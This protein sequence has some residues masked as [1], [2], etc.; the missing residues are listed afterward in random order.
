MLLCYFVSRKDFSILN[1]TKINSYSIAHNLDCGGKSKIVIAENPNASDEDFVLIKEGKEIKFGG[2]IDKIDNANGEMKH[3]ISCLEIEQL[4]N[5]EIFLSD[6]DIIKTTGIED[7]IAATI[8]NYFA[9]T[10]DSFIDLSY[11][12]CNAATHTKINAKPPAEDGI[13]NFKTYLGNVKQQYGIFL[14]FD[15]TSTHL[16]I[17][18][19]KKEQSAMQIDTTLTDIYNCEES[20]KIK[21]LS[22]LSVLWRNTT[23]Q[24]ETMRYFYLHSD[25]SV[26]EVDKDRI[27]GT[28]SAICIE[29]ETEEEMIQAAKD[30][31]KSN[32]YSHSIEADILIN[33]K[34][35]PI[36]ELYVGHEVK[37]KTAA[38][39][40]QESIISE[41][42][43]TDSAD[44][45]AVKFGILKVKLT[46]KLKS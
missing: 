21:V 5:R 24:A 41:V 1:V 12:R 26:S 9:N 27:D 43:F 17:T 33:S 45:V 40:I 28:I 38:A 11:I 20:Y 34:L 16:N 39:G 14:E 30:E 31:F 23:T 46:D 37:I 22:K 44:V 29:A 3:N 6:A 18:I 32:S 8:E 13:Y 10:G 15:F 25:R 42:S 35:Y 2:I 7:F 19:R 4:F 36:D